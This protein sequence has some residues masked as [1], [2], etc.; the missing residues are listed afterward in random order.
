MD[1]AFMKFSFSG[2]KHTPSFFLLTYSM[3]LQL[4]QVLG[5]FLYL[6]KFSYI[7]E[8]LRIKS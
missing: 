3:T 2:L 8:G 1:L 6:C 4:L 7:Y 5:R